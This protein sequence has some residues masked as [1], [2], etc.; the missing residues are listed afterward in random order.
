MKH[1]YIFIALLLF[2]FA[3]ACKKNNDGFGQ[4][5]YKFFVNA[6]AEQSDAIPFLWSEGD[7]VCV[8]NRQNKSYV[9]TLCDGAG[10]KLAKFGSTVKPDFGGE[11][12]YFSLYPS[13]LLQSGTLYWPAEQQFDL[14]DQR[15]SDP[16]CATGSINGSELQDG[17]FYSLGGVLTLELKMSESSVGVNV[18]KVTLNAKQSICGPFQAQSGSGEARVARLIESPESGKTISIDIKSDK[19][20]GLYLETGKTY[21]IPVALP[22]SSEAGYTGLSLS[23]YDASGAL[24]SESESIDEPC[25]KRA[26]VAK[27][28]FEI[29]VVPYGAGC[30]SISETR[31]VRFSTGNLFVDTTVSP[32][33]IGMES[34][35]RLDPY[36]REKN[37]I[38][39]F[40]WAKDFAT[41]YA[42]TYDDD[43]RDVND[44]LF[45]NNPEIY[46][47]YGLDWFI[48]SSSEWNYLLH[49]RQMDN[50]VIRYIC[51]D[52]GMYIYPDDFDGKDE[53]N[54]VILPYTSIISAT[55]Q[56]LY[57]CRESYDST[58]S[59]IGKD[60][61][62]DKD[63][64]T[65][66]M[67][68][69]HPASPGS[70]AA[71]SC[72]MLR[73]QPANIRFVKEIK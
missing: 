64:A 54:A 20:D 70:G 55:G 69:R 71:M 29:S 56:G 5:S 60:P 49:Q 18:A 17:V 16:R 65:A 42:N 35:K 19:Q 73:N 21:S 3:V 25:I 44:I 37:H 11:S 12:T 59:D 23:L 28:S 1:R 51:L 63:Q 32:V 66:L 15:L 4:D 10:S 58:K 53:T 14:D 33:S 24:L 26:Q 40:F 2:S 46:N 62:L 7:K 68:S 8:M 41:S 72:F 6:E 48:L 52:D 31:K 57:W 13:D 22:E 27:A 36:T 39:T 9:Y 38:A 47:I 43:D 67:F 45:Q 30:F 50:D 61:L 34:G